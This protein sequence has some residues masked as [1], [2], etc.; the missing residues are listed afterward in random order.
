MMENL[1]FQDHQLTPTI[2]IIDLFRL[3]NSRKNLAIKICSEI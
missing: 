2:H 1:M 3:I